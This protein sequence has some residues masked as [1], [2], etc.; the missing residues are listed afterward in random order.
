MRAPQ[1]L[2]DL[3]HPLLAPKWSGRPWRWYHRAGL[4]VIGWILDRFEMWQWREGHRLMKEK[5][6]AMEDLARATERVRKAYEAAERRSPQ[7]TEK[8]K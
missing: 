6:D 2:Y 4:A 5:A 7:A 3:R 8:D 1:W